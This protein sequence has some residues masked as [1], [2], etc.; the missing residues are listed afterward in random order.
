MSPSLYLKYLR[1]KEEIIIHLI[2]NSSGIWEFRLLN[3]N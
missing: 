2:T 3:F 1:Q